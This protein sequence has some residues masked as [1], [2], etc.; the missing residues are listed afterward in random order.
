MTTLNKDEV[1]AL[2]TKNFEAKFGR[3][4]EVEAK[5]GWYKVDG[6]KGLRLADLQQYAESLVGDAPAAEAAAPVANATPKKAAPAKKA[7]PKAKKAV[8]ATG[9]NGGKTW[10]QVWA[11]KLSADKN[12]TLP[13]G[14]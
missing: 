8:K 14:F 1:I 13:R 4:P 5:G 7:A 9:S 10:K 6:G 12:S 2:V 3:T 11:E